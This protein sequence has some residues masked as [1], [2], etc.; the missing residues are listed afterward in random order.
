MIALPFPI[1]LGWALGY[2]GNYMADVLPAP[3]R[4]T[5]PVCSE[6]GTPFELSGYL[7][8]KPC[9]QC[10]RRRPWRFWVVQFAMAAASAYIWLRAPARLGYAF[11]L[12]ILIY[13]GIVFV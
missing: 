10:G 4:F 11:G 8:G 3:R 5:R 6:C 9:S 2:L 7:L 13:F 12:V 1:L